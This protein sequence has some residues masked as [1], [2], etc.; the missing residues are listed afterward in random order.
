MKRPQE[1]ATLPLPS[2]KR[3]RRDH[4][5]VPPASAPGASSSSS[6]SSAFGGGAFSVAAAAEAALELSSPRRR[7]RGDERRGGRSGSGAHTDPR[8]TKNVKRSRVASSLS[9]SYAAAPAVPPTA[10]SAAAA[11][12]KRKRRKRDDGTSEAMLSSPNSD[13]DEALSSSAETAL[14]DGGTESEGGGESSSGGGSSE[15]SPQASLRW[16]GSPS[17]HFQR[18]QL[19]ERIDESVVD[20]PRGLA[21]SSASSS[22][23]AAVS[24]AAVSSTAASRLPIPPAGAAASASASIDVS[25]SSSSSSPPP[26]CRPAGVLGTAAT[27][28]RIV[29]IGAARRRVQNHYFDMNSELRKLA[30]DRRSRHEERNS[31]TA[32]RGASASASAAPPL[33]SLVSPPPINRAAFRIVTPAGGATPAEAEL[34]RARLR[35]GREAS[36]L[37]GNSSGGEG[38]VEM[39]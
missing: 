26:R 10:A 31:A 11:A 12:A 36:S 35:A 30:I 15:A 27:P 21:S 28:I 5:H 8:P 9:L 33:P 34:R 7:R 38:D 2:P 39:S 17:R 3:A 6:S 37:G 25:S 16:S 19:L 32:E 14:G 1:R 24:T 13:T 4:T 23:A 20:S 22:N 18:M 29:E